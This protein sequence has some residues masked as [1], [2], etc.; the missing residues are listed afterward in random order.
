MTKRTRTCILCGTGLAL[1][2]LLCVIFCIVFSL[3]SAATANDA[4]VEAIQDVAKEAE[5][6][7]SGPR[8]VVDETGALDMT[9]LQTYQTRIDQTFT[10]NFGLI[11]QGYNA[12]QQICDSF[13]ETTDVVLENKIIDF[14]T[15]SLQIDGDTATLVC[16]IMMLQKYIPY[17]GEGAYRA[18]FGVSTTTE[19]FGFVKDEGGA[20]RVSSS[21]EMDYQFGS[22]RDMGMSNEDLE[23]I[24]P[25]REEACAY[26]ASLSVENICP[27]LRVN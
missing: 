21:S 5:L 6:L 13:D 15:K 4:D 12:M 25:T 14:S 8:N 27:L 10:S 23:K 18:V 26:A 2:V 22:T 17:E 9:C 20:W 1:V 7:I 3:N 16:D 11:E 19:T 24:F